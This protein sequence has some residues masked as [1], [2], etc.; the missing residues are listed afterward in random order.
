M[1]KTI[2]KLAIRRETLRIL[3]DADLRRV[4]GG[5]ETNCTLAS[6]IASGCRTNVAAE[7]EPGIG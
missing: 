4:A 1:K 6:K 2:T 7:E 5:E 3:I